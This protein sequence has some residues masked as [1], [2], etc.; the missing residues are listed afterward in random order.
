MKRLC[1]GLFAAVAAWGSTPATLEWHT[2]SDDVFKEAKSENRFVLLD[3]EAIWCHWCHVMDTTT[4]KDPQT[5]E[6]LKSKYIVVK[7]DQDSRPDLATRYEDYG[8]P[9]TIVFDSSG[10]EIV[11][12][13]GYIPPQE[14]VS[15]LKA[16]IKDPTP[17]P[18][19]VPEEPVQFADSP[20][21]SAEA[22]K[23]LQDRYN[24]AY[25]WK[26]GSWGTVQ[27]FLDWDGTEYAM[28]LARKGDAQAEKMARQ[29]LDAQLN[30]L[31]PAWGGVY[32]Y[33]TDGDWKHAHFEKIMQFQ[34]EDLRI[35]SIGYAQFHEQRYLHAAQAIRGFLKT[36]LTSPDGAF[37]TSM[38]ADLV[39]GKHSANYFALS[40]AGRRKQGVP[41]VDKHIY[42]RENGWAISGMA[43]LYQ[44]TGDEAVLADAKRAAEYIIANR[45]IEGGG[46]RHGDKDAAGPYLNDTLAMTRAFLALY[47]STGDREWLKRAQDS[48]HYIEANFR[49]TA[50][51]GYIASRA[52]TVGGFSARPERDENVALARTANLLFQYTGDE[53]YQKV[54]QEAMKYVVTPKIMRENSALPTLLA[55]LELTASPV[56]LTIVGHKDD[57][58]AQALFHTALQFPSGYKRIE[59]WDTR[60]G[61]LPNPDVQYPELSKAAAFV[62]TQK[63]CSSPIFQADQLLAKA[64][65][66]SR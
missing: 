15:M 36:F 34:A 16:I 5:I 41:K 38:D 7:V 64:E 57:T 14:M 25:D 23:K 46:F 63:S 33:S 54:S 11:K 28:D 65:K 24:A 3:L 2:W 66:L 59:W 60:E 53:G 48:M 4:Y 12:R 43:A 39:E 50:G 62:C 22:R 35:Y 31:D 13:Q 20:F 61:R 56:H 8:W 37:Y 10:Q 49:N 44:A 45:S 1:L 18:S 26:Y 21:L 9:A 51:A 52:S 19:V 55:E 58:A 27:K 29:T 42:S 6:L 17:G 30:L 47:A 40:D 32:Q